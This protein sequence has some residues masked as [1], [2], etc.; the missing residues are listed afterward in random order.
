MSGVEPVGDAALP[1]GGSAPPTGS[2]TAA[3]GTPV[4]VDL[5]P[6]RR[7]RRIWVVL[8]GGPVIWFAHFMVVYLVAEAGCTGGGAGLGAFDP[9]V[10]RI[11]TVASTAIA[12]LACAAVAWRGHRL[13]RALDAGALDDTDRHGEGA[14]WGV[15][16]DPGGALAYAGFLLASVFT[17]A[18]LFVGVPAPFLSAC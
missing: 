10:P 5:A 13:W 15:G 6:D 2:A 11:V 7:A 18:V 17:V 14:G 16:R 8:L 4:P 12:A 3:G 1:A 9:P